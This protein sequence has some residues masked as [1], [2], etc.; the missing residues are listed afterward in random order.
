MRTFPQKYQLDAMDCGP[1][2]LCM[3]ADYYGKK[4]LPSDFQQDCG[5]TREGI[6]MLGLSEAAEAQGL[7]T[8]CAK[9]TLDQLAKEI[10]LPCILHWNLKYELY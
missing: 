6:T 7:Q 9:I 8:L 2:C 10:I 1:T 3:I 4:C 5:I